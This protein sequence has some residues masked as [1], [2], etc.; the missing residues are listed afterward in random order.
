MKETAGDPPTV[1]LVDP[2]RLRPRSPRPVQ[3]IK[4]LA[5][6]LP[7][8]RVHKDAFRR[9]LLRHRAPTL[10]NAPPRMAEQAGR[11]RADGV[12]QFACCG[13]RDH[14]E[15]RFSILVDAHR[16]PAHSRVLYERPCAVDGIDGQAVSFSCEIPA[17][18]LAHK[19][20]VISEGIAHHFLRKQFACAVGLRH[21]TVV[22][23]SFATRAC[24]DGGGN[25]LLIANVI[26]S[27]SKSNSL[28]LS[29]FKPCRT[30]MSSS[31]C[32]SMDS[33]AIASQDTRFS[34]LCIRGI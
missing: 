12:H 2:F 23:L 25:F 13:L 3:R 5:I 20:N 4:H 15:V 29:G 8:L 9:R 11:F 21:R 26:C 10:R 19:G 28:S 1:Q 34:H 16:R 22:L 30:R 6:V 32:V 31:A 18:L 27:V 7:C 24:T 14:A 17:G 33:N